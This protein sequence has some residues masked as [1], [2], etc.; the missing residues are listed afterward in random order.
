MLP[1]NCFARERCAKIASIL[2][3]VKER[4]PEPSLPAP[5]IPI[6][7]DHEVLRVIGRGAYGEIWL[8][9]GLTGALRAVKVVYR[10][11]FDSERAFQR[12]FPGDVE[13]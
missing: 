6:I 5:H 10:S 7:P 11:T 9:R 8:A 2:D 12:E 3:D 13:L 1:R 4:A